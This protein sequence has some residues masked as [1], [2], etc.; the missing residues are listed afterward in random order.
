MA[1]KTHYI[2]TKDNKISA[3]VYN[4]NRRPIKFKSTVLM[5]TYLTVA[6]LM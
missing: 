5:V 1:P 2:V 4:D 3:R 6:F